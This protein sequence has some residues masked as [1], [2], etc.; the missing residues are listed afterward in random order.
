MSCANV[1]LRFRGKT[2]SL[3]KE[4]V[5]HRFPRYDAS[6]S[7][8]QQQ[9]FVESVPSNRIILVVEHLYPMRFRKL[10]E[11]VTYK[12]SRASRFR[13]EAYISELLAQI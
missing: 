10:C 1:N 8:F 5:C 11:V 7:S 9:F 2:R 13:V 12:I 4:T 6:R 3:R